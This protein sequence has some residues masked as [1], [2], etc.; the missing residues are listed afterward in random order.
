[1]LSI[2]EKERR[3]GFRERIEARA[4]LRRTYRVAIAVLGGLVLVAGIVMIPYPGPGWAVVFAGL[5]ILATEFIWARRV[6]QY[7][8]S[9]YDAWTDWLRRQSLLVRLTVLAGTGLVVVATLY[10][11]NAFYLVAGLVGLGEWTW[12]QSPFF[13]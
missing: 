8:R 3:P 7:A 11:L 9:K 5:A 4:T 12:L 6:L 1:V 10:L 13:G 2:T